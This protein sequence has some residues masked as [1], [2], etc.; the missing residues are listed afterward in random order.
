[1]K[2]VSQSARITICTLLLLS[3]TATL[4]YYHSLDAPF[5]FDDKDN[6]TKNPHI[7]LTDLS[8][9]DLADVLKSRSS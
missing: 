6:I 5:V 3:L 1:M 8:W 2:I 4:I 7:Q 9:S